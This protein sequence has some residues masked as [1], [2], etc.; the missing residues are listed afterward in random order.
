M[1]EIHKLVFSGVLDL[2]GN[3]WNVKEKPAN[4]TSFS[5]ENKRLVSCI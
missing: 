5:C 3:L 4:K 1:E 2:D